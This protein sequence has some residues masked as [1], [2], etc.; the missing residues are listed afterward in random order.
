[1]MGVKELCS[2]NGC[3]K[4][5]SFC[6]VLFIV[7]S[8]FFLL[9]PYPFFFQFLL[10]HFFIRPSHPLSFYL[11]ILCPSFV[12]LKLFHIV[13]SSGILHHPHFIYFLHSLF[14]H[15]FVLL[16]ASYFPSFV[17]FTPLPPLSLLLLLIYFLLCLHTLFLIPSI[18][19]SKCFSYLRSPTFR[20]R[21]WWF[22]S[23]FWNSLRGSSGWKGKSRC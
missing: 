4:I 10:P 2:K 20:P 22:L 5:V 9:F 13:S 7:P 18:L 15:F 3:K 16:L 19:F 1:M 17:L 11:S 8:C 12:H 14:S 23:L 6:L 21:T